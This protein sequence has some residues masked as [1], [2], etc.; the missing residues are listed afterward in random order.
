[1]QR[2]AIIRKERSSVGDGVHKSGHQGIQD[3][4]IFHYSMNEKISA[5]IVSRIYPVYTA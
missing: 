3:L 4:F 2:M 5:E 1:M